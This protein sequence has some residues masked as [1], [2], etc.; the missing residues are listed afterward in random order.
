MAAAACCWLVTM[1]SASSYRARLCAS[2]RGRCGSARAQ[3]G[4]IEQVRERR[5]GH[6]RPNSRDRGPGRRRLHR[7]VH[8]NSRRFRA[9]RRWT[10]GR[11][12]GG[13]SAPAR[14]PAREPRQ[15]RPDAPGRADARCATR[16]ARRR[17]AVRRRAGSPAFTETMPGVTPRNARQRRLRQHERLTCLDGSRLRRGPF[18]VGAR[19]LRARPELVVGQRV[20]G[21]GEDVPALHVGLGRGNRSFR[22]DH[23]K[24]G[25][26]HRTLHVEACQ[27]FVR[28][29][30]HNCRLGATHGGAAETEVERFPREQ[31]ARGAAPDASTRKQT[32][33][34]VR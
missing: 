33:A 23:G 26:A 13:R 2:R 16:S 32:A 12:A 1:S 7:A 11:V 22:G 29:R 8:R 27:R 21:A 20:R 28:A 30:T 19:R 10:A 25:R 4:E 3:A 5:P 34:P 24:E 6:P 15:R 31:C 9:R 17:R 14:P 18:R